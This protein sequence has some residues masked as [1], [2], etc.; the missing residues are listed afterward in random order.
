VV[1]CDVRDL[2][3]RTREDAFD[4]IRLSAAAGAIALDRPH[5]VVALPSS[6]VADGRVY[7]FEVSSPAGLYA[8]G[9]HE[10]AVAVRHGAW[11]VHGTVHVVVGSTPTVSPAVWTTSGPVPADVSAQLPQSTIVPALEGPGLRVAVRRIHLAAEQARRALLEDNRGLVRTVVNR[12]RAVLRAEASSLELA[13]LL[14][15]A[16]HQLLDVVDRSFTAPD[17]PRPRDVAWS[18]LVQRAIGGAVRAEVARATGISV[19]FRQLLAWFHANPQDRHAPAIDVARR[20]AFA[21][22]VTRLMAARVISSRGAAAA[23]LDEMLER[24]AARYVP[25][26]HGAGEERRRLRSAG[27]FVISPRS[28]LAEIERAQSFNGTAALTLDDDSSPMAGRDLRIAHIDHGYGETDTTDFLR[29]TIEQ[30]GMSP[31]EALVWLHRSGALDPGGHGSE[32]PDIA[33]TLGLSGRAEARAALRRARRKLD[34]WVGELR[35]A[36]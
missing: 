7:D 27:V 5:G 1:L 36:N 31:I 35:A 26:V 2:A 17:A 4:A 29:R 6:V 8:P 16:E 18:K 23:E 9:H 10:I 3:A 34:S 21:A 15:V 32:L 19:E 30:T 11:A 24:G 14:V 20:M 22:G 12:Y 33:E 28:S 13:D 25:P